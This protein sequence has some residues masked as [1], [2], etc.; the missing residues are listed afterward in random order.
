MGIELDGERVQ[1]GR[2][3]WLEQREEALLHTGVEKESRR[4][5][6]SKMEEMGPSTG[7]SGIGPRDSGQ[8]GRGQLCHCDPSPLE[9]SNTNLCVFVCSEMC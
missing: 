4:P 3:R 5:G 7:Q 2:G 9:N 1:D 6:N 8:V